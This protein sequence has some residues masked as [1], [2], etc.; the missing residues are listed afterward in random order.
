M[1]RAGCSGRASSEVFLAGFITRTL[2]LALGDKGLRALCAKVRAVHAPA[3]LVMR[4]VHTDRDRH[5]QVGILCGIMWW[6]GFYAYG[7]SNP[8]HPYQAGTSSGEP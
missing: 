1:R 8:C 4:L 7:A 6:V 5:W 3:M 2:V